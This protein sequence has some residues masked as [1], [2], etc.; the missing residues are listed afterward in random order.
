MGYNDPVGDNHEQSNLLGSARGRLSADSQELFGTTKIRHS[1]FR[2]ASIKSIKIS[3]VGHE[4]FAAYVD[5]NHDIKQEYADETVKSKAEF[6]QTHWQSYVARRSR[7]N[8]QKTTDQYVMKYNRVVKT[9]TWNA[10]SQTSAGG[11]GSFADAV[12]VPVN[13][14]DTVEFE[15]EFNDMGPYFENYRR[16]FNNNYTWRLARQEG[17]LPAPIAL[18][19]SRGCSNTRHAFQARYMFTSTQF[20]GD[21]SWSVAFSPNDVFNNHDNMN[22]AEPWGDVAILKPKPVTGLT[23][24]G[25]T[26]I[27]GK[28]SGI[29]CTAE[30]SETIDFDGVL[31][32]LTT[33]KTGDVK[34]R[35]YQDRIIPRHPERFVPVATDDKSESSITGNRSTGS[36]QQPASV[37]SPSE[38]EYVTYNFRADATVS[39]QIRNYDGVTLANWDYTIHAADII[40]TITLSRV[41]DTA[42]SYINGPRL[43]ESSSIDAV[44]RFDK[45]S[46]KNLTPGR[47]PSVLVD[48]DAG[49]SYS[50]LTGNWIGAKNGDIPNKVFNVYANTLP[51]CE[52]I[53]EYHE[54]GQWKQAYSIP[55]TGH[56]ITGAD[57]SEYDIL[58]N[59]LFW[60]YSN[61]SRQ[62][63]S[64]A[65]PLSGPWRV[66]KKLTVN[67]Q[68]NAC[69]TS[70]PAVHIATMSQWDV[71]RFSANPTVSTTY[72]NYSNIIGSWETCPRHNITLKDENNQD[73][74]YTLDVKYEVEFKLL[75][76]N[77]TQT[78]KTILTKIVNTP[79][80]EVSRKDSELFISG[81]KYKMSIGVIHCG[82]DVLEPTVEKRWQHFHVSN[83]AVF[84]IL[85]CND[86][87]L[88]DKDTG[89]E[90]GE[91]TITTLVNRHGHKHKSHD[92]MWCQ[93]NNHIKM[94]ACR[95]YGAL[96]GNLDVEYEWISASLTYEQCK[97][98]AFERGGK[99]AQMKT[100][101]QLAKFNAYLA[102]NPGYNS[103]WIGLT[104][105]A[106]EGV[107]RWGDGE[108]A[109][110]DCMNWYTGEPNNGGG[111][112]DYA[113][114]IES[115]GG[116][117][118][119]WHDGTNSYFIQRSKPD[120][121]NYS[122]S[123]YQYISGS[124]THSSASTNAANR[125]GRLAVMK[126]TSDR[127]KVIAAWKSAGRPLAYIG[128]TRNRGRS[129]WD[130]KNGWKWADGTWI[131]KYGVRHWGGGE[132]NS[133]GETAVHI[134]WHGEKWN[135]CRSNY[136]QGYIL[137]LPTPDTTSNTVICSSSKTVIVA[138][139]KCYV[140]G[141][142]VM[143]F[144]GSQG[145]VTPVKNITNI[146]TNYNVGTKAQ[147]AN[148]FYMNISN[149]SLLNVTNL[150]NI[151]ITPHNR[152]S[153]GRIVNFTGEIIDDRD[154]PIAPGN[155]GNVS[156]ERLNNDICRVVIDDPGGAVLSGKAHSTCPDPNGDMYH[157]NIYATII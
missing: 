60:S 94:N 7:L 77:S 30:S 137:E 81:R 104:D 43:Y 90:I 126:N 49:A 78:E 69:S 4:D 117:W 6:G 141:G 147:A 39:G 125:G 99:L 71:D 134:G 67:N 33:G 87:D 110:V 98:D 157:F 11:V 89:L 136:H 75:K 123:S 42:N 14:G 92:I 31:T 59:N 119:D 101:E 73:V 52:N 85:D 57:Q 64:K 86:P 58:K 118:N 116:K 152:N 25:T 19:T 48:A 93:P 72:S 88:R 102:A 91:Q 22:P 10:P 23:L 37:P 108:E 2:V 114:V 142:T 135:D 26:N 41:P 34:F 109:A 96:G 111:N 50:K 38:G 146:T 82:Y 155:R 140:R 55:S 153:G 66:T 17:N 150:N 79:K 131:E 124:F 143:E 107:W 9:Y 103:G 95:D 47:W 154:D 27:A 70:T 53:L 148:S 1:D 115:W 145:G 132:P 18:P 28:T 12:E 129:T 35:W 74:S 149:D 76:S 63:E 44:A 128:L 105:Q 32:G 24:T 15:V 113:N 36:S 20:T 45:K 21:Q 83:S 56:R 100:P 144:S 121:N 8:G 3:V 127:D 138:E 122:N 46:F 13:F 133:F 139:I 5:N 97:A 68:S 51:N 156:I 65:W 40:S 62:V 130:N 16:Y 29:V 54:D 80:Y 151:S 84:E 112:E 120:S 61:Y 106:D